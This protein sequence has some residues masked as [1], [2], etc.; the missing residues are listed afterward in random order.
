MDDITLM[1]AYIKAELPYLYKWIWSHNPAASYTFSDGFMM[2]GWSFLGL[3]ESN[4]NVTRVLKPYLHKRPHVDGGPMD[5]EPEEKRR[6]VGPNHDFLTTS[7]NQFSS[8]SNNFNQETSRIYNTVESTAGSNSLYLISSDARNRTRDLTD[9]AMGY[10]GYAIN[11][12]SSSHLISSD[13]RNLTDPAMGN[14]GYAI[15]GSSSSHLISS[16]ARDLTD[17][18]MGNFSYAVNSSNGITDLATA[19]FFQYMDNLDYGY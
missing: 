18:A 2:Y 9:P 7:F 12:S 16:D 17:P 8:S 13:A 4:T 10:F 15:N 5:S 19:E 3:L 1:F 6:R 11:G 14:F